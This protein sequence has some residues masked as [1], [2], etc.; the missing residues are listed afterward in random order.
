MSGARAT[1]GVRR[2]PTPV[3]ERQR[4]EWNPARSTS[5][6]FQ[7]SGSSRDDRRRRERTGRV[8]SAPRLRPAKHTPRSSLEVDTGVPW[9][10]WS[11]D[12]WVRV[13]RS[14][15][16]GLSRSGDSRYP[17]TGDR[18]EGSP[19]PGRSIRTGSGRLRRRPLLSF[20]SILHLCC[21]RLGVA[22]RRGPGAPV[23][24]ARMSCVPIRARWRRTVP[25]TVERDSW[26]DRSTD[27][28]EVDGRHSPPGG[29]DHAVISVDAGRRRGPGKVHAGLRRSCRGGRPPGGRR[30]GATPTPC[31]PAAMEA[32]F[33]GLS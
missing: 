25:L 8:A 14:C 22:L 29:A 11:Q 32:P 5:R 2:G 17:V 33:S 23:E 12:S 10:G 18:L 21:R 24:S 1:S 16:P 27:P 9:T 20:G 30:F 28:V 13:R 15:H 26:I 6:A 19:P 4:V 3:V 7:P 31:P